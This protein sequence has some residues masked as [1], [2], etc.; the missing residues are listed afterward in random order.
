MQRIVKLNPEHISVYSLVVEEKTPIEE[1]IKNKELILPEEN[2]E[3]KMYWE[4]KK[5]L[6]KNGYKHYE[7]S[8]YAKP[9]FESKHN[10]NCW[11]QKEYFGFGVGAHSYTDGVRYSNT[12]NIE[13]YIENYKNG[14]QENNFIFHEKQDK[15]SQM[16]E[17]IMLGLRKI[18]GVK[19]SEFKEKFEIDIKK[20]FNMELEKLLKEKLITED[21]KTIKL[22]NKGID[23]ANLV[24]QEFV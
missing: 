13:D 17:F 1:K 21:E 5:I 15:L 19:K 7:I 14:K 11:E 23:L 4:V 18:E 10:S 12:E 8:N 16:K 2:V 3:R 9:G 24:W 22:S 6:E 20:F